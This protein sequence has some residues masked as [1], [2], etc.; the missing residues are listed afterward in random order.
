MQIVDSVGGTITTAWDV[1]DR[2]TTETTALGV[3]RYDN[4]TNPADRG[5]DTLGR[6]LWMEVS[7]Q[8]RV[9]YTWDAASRLTQLQQGSQVVTFAYDNANR[10]TLLTLPNGASTEYQYDLASQLTAL[11]YRNASA[12]E[13]G[14]LAYGHDL[15]GNRTRLGESFAGTLF[16]SAVTEASY[17]AGNRQTAFGSQVLAYDDNGNLTTI[18]QGTDITALIWDSRN[19]LTAFSSPTTAATF[20][21]DALGR[22]SAKTVDGTTTQFQY[23]GLD[24]VRE[25]VGSTATGYLNGPSIDE[26]LARGGAEFYWADA[27][28][29][30]LRLTD[31]GGAIATAYGYEPFGRAS[32]TSGASTNSAQYTGREVDGTG[33][34][35]YR[36]RYY[37]PGLQRF[38]SEDPI[39]FDG[40]DVNLYA[41]VA[42]DPLNYTDPT[43]QFLLAGCASGAL[44]NVAFD[45]GAYLLAG[46]KSSFGEVLGNAAVGCISGAV[47]GPL[48]QLAGRLVL[49]VAVGRAVSM[50]AGVLARSLGAASR[51]EELARKLGLNMNSATTRQLLNNLDMPV[52]EFVG[53]FRKASI[54]RRL[55]GEVLEA[56]VTVEQALLSYGSTVRKLLTAGR[57]AK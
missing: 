37:H 24:M 10:R 44:T 48:F 20:S 42:N 55:P 30:V 22:R 17:N 43:G 2:L 9:I 38:L 36:A 29:S 46:R 4:P 18:T 54:L 16:P 57:F 51:A 11:V 13:L 1:L 8:A 31:A 27:L 25:L 56:G 26:P 28:G 35:Y 33:L 40:G 50:E 34:Y 19:R 41:Y 5:Y 21:Y 39:G 7:G 15:A 47:G 14:R 12:T 45:L 6:R 3:V 49:R 32:V 23:D 52:S 53:L